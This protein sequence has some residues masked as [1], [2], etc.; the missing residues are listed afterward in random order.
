LRLPDGN[1]INKLLFQVDASQFHWRKKD[2]ALIQNFT[3]KCYLSLTE[4]LFRGAVLLE[5]FMNKINEFETDNEL[6]EFSE[7]FMTKMLGYRKG[8]VIKRKNSSEILPL[9]GFEVNNEFLL[10]SPLAEEKISSYNNQNENLLSSNN[11][12]NIEVLTDRKKHRGLNLLN[13][14]DTNVTNV[15]VQISLNQA[16]NNPPKISSVTNN[17]I[18]NPPN[19]N[20]LNN[21]IKNISLLNEIELYVPLGLSELIQVFLQVFPDKEFMEIA[22]EWARGIKKDKTTSHFQ[23]KENLLQYLNSIK[24][25]FPNEEPKQQALKTLENM[26]VLKEE[27]LKIEMQRIKEMMELYGDFIRI[28]N[29]RLEERNLTSNRHSPFHHRTTSK[30]NTSEFVKKALKDKC[31]NLINRKLE[32]DGKDDLID[33]RERALESPQKKDSKDLVV[34]EKKGLDEIKKD[35]NDLCYSLNNNNANNFDFFMG[36]KNNNEHN[37]ISM[38]SSKNQRQ[39]PGSQGSNRSH[40]KTY[41]QN[42]NVVVN[43]NAVGNGNNQKKTILKKS[44]TMKFEHQENNNEEEEAVNY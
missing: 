35:I 15:S 44:S 36:S 28:F 12:N 2:L 33:N 37:N 13:M 39:K 34:L 7:K 8:F 41:Y 30:E 31:I 21:I 19:N 4:A 24:A 16:P 23:S 18:N 14:Q 6:D 11:N 27:A 1:T 17:N 42:N 43:N 5:L 40:F 29:R 9:T 22:E 25:Q 3:F 10:S 38:S 20:N 26:I 32:N